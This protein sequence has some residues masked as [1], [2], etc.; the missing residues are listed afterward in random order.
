MAGQIKY[1]IEFSYSKG[2]VTRSRKWEG[3]ES[4][5]TDADNDVESYVMSVPTGGVPVPSYVL[6]GILALKNLDSTNYHEVWALT[7]DPALMQVKPGDVAIFPVHD[8]LSFLGNHIQANTAAALLELT[9]F[10]PRSS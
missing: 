1:R 7:T 9:A 5:D 4:F 3:V 8:T 10:P 2:G 6:G